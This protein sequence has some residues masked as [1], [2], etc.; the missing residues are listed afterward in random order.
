MQE[1]WHKL[2][3]DL[4]V[5]ETVTGHHLE[6]DGIPKQTGIPKPPP[7][8]GFEKQLINDVIVTLRSVT[9]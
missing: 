6:F 7:F 8:G 3:S 2:T 4:W 9:A 1:N 5:L